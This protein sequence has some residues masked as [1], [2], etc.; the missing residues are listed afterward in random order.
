MSVIHKFH[1]YMIQFHLATTTDTKNTQVLTI[2]E[3]LLMPDF[4]VV[5]SSKI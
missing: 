1:Y 4:K 2:N 5:D 3:L